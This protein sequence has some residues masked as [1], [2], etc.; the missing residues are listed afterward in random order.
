MNPLPVH[1]DAVIAATRRWVER[2]VIGLNLCPFAKGVQ[3]KGQ[4]HYVVSQATDGQEVLND[5]KSELEALHASDP[6]Q[7]DTTLLIAPQAF[8]D[9]LDFLNL[10]QR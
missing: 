2:A 7:R 9:F 3:T 4:V 8:V 1:T 10:F 6:A 5:L